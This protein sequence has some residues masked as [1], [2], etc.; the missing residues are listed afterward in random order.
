M[1]GQ[2]SSAAPLAWIY[3]GLIV[4]ASLYP[5]SGW[6]VP[7][8]SPWHFLLLPWSRWWTWFDLVSNLHL[9]QVE[10]HRL[11]RRVPVQI[12]E[13]RRCDRILAHRFGWHARRLR[14]R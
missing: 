2:R 6:R 13:R 7:G 14:H 3:A 8:V 4:Y 9:V 1:P 5:F 12:V 10:E 11:E